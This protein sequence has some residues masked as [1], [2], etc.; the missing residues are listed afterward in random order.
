MQRFRVSIEAKVWWMMQT[1]VYPPRERGTMT[2]PP[3]AAAV[4]G[5]CSEWAIHDAYAADQERQRVA[6]EH[7]KAKTAAARKGPGGG[8]EGDESQSVSDTAVQVGPVKSCSRREASGNPTTMPGKP[9]AVFVGGRRERSTSKLEQTAI[10][11]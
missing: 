10:S 6:E 8:A 7:A 9:S 11:T 3:P 4:G 5:G 1:T 2:E